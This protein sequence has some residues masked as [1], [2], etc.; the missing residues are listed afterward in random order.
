MAAGQKAEA[1]D[2]FVKTLEIEIRNPT[3]VFY[4]VKCAYETKKYEDAERLVM[5]FVEVAPV[6]A[7]L[8][9]SLAGL[10]YH[11]GRI[12]DAL[13]VANKIQQIKP[14]HHGARELIEMIASRRTHG[15][16]G[17]FT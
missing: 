7:N 6:N 16:R 13:R 15:S 9:Y 3:S 17:H 14:D 10:H 1:L 8:L 2:C 11:L 5:K 12:E 4:L